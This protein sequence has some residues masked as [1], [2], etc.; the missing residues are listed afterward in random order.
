MMM[1]MKD[2]E[3]TV[4]ETISMSQPPSSG[5]ERNYILKNTIYG[6]FVTVQW[7]NATLSLPGP[8]FNSWVG[9]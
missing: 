4:S 6:S 2:D 7:Q 8:G 1:M 5:S 9:S 3:K